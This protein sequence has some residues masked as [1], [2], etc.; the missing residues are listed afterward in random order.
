MKDGPPDTEVGEDG[1][2]RR[3]EWFAQQLGEHWASPG[4]G[5]YRYVKSASDAAEP[6]TQ[7]GDEDLVDALDPTRHAQQPSD[8]GAPRTSAGR[9]RR[10]LRR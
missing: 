10:W 2:G 7:S 4:D 8:D 5:I 6:S 3:G 9:R 1:E